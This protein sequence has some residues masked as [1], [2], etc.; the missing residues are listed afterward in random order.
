MVHLI[1]KGVINGRKKNLHNR[2]HVFTNA[3]GDK[4]MYEFMHDNPSME[5]YPV[6]HTNNPQVIAANDNMISINSTIEVDLLGSATRS[7][8]GFEFSGTGAS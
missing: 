1:K 4:E 7:N 6:S 2:K 8:R 3:I 5:S